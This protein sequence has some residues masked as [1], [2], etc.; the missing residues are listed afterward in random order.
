[1]TVVRDDDGWAARFSE[2]AHEVADALGRVVAVHHCGSTAVPGLAAKPVIDLLVEVPALAGV[3]ARAA[4]MVA[5][6]YEALGEYG[7]PR[8]RFFRRDDAAGVRTH[9]VHVWPVGD[10]EV[11][12]HLAFRDYLV[13]HPDVARAYGALKTDLA[14]AHPTD[15]EAYMD[16]K[17]AFVKA[18]T[19][20]ALA[21][22][23]AG[24]R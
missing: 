20:R 4:A 7:L 22:H 24:R 12:R 5:L 21:W 23:D 1:V 2:A 3:D 19:A 17:D 8:R 6:G 16:G 11:L 10:A 15:I 14:H 9:H 18:H 13:A